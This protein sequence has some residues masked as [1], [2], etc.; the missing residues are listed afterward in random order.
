LI[1]PT[2]IVHPSAEI[3]E[4]VEI[5]PYSIIG[6]DVFIGRN[7]WIG[8]HVVI[9][10]PTRIGEDNRI[11]QFA[12]LGGE[13]QDKKYAGEPTTLEIGDRNTI[14]EYC[15]FSRGT[16]QDG[17][18]TRFGNDNWVMA[19]VHIAHDCQ[20]GNNII[21]ANCATLAGHVTIE[22]NVI[23]GGFTAV[24]QF[25]RLGRHSFTAMASAIPKDVPPYVMVS[26]NFAHPHGLNI[27]GLKRRGIDKDEIMEIR[28]AYKILYKQGLTLE[29]AKLELK[30]MSKNSDA[31]Q[32]MLT[33]IN[34]SQRGILR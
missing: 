11:F 16:I 34:E 4:G 27:E 33:F 30:E 6:A 13:P 22:D 3:A 23:L 26:G 1:H 5:G 21:F 24:H 15:T 17:G 20:V 19:Y 18:V 28:R 9:E 2:A 8:P 7:T 14:R 10:G 25:C 12:S 29:N 31:V 32:D